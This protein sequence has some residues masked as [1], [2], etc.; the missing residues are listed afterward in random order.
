MADD[1]PHGRPIT[2]VKPTE[3][4]QFELDEEALASV[5]NDPAI[6]DK[7]VVVLSV[8]GAFRKGKS[9]LLDFFLRYLRNQGSEDWLGARDQPLTGFSWRGGMDRDTTGILLWSEV[10]TLNMA[11][12][13]E[14]AVL[15][16]DT[17]GAFDS[18]S[19]VKDCATVFALSTMLSSVL[20]YNLSQ[21]IQEDDLQHLQLFTEYG[22]LALDESGRT[23]FQKLCF[24]IRDWS[25]PYE[26]AYG[27]DGGRQVLEKRL[28]VSERQHPELQQLRKHIRSCFADLSC[29]LLPHP[30]LRVATDPKF[31][32]KLADIEDLFTKFIGELI[33]SFLAPDKL[34]IKEIGGQKVTCRDLVQYFKSYVEIYKGGSLPE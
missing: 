32:G 13:E 16:L 4:H 29:F 33:P 28:Q 20:I 12:G 19:T 10:F 7:H 11:S 17:Q 30:G 8:A 23:P 25:F 31:D 9:F 15:L 3:D 26:S 6:K 21:N 2:I 22:R 34:V 24:L 5:L 27:I 18:D 1:V 14:V